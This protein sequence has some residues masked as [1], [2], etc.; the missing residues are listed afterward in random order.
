[1]RTILT[2]LSCTLAASAPALAH[3]PL[4]WNGSQFEVLLDADESRGSIGIFTETVPAPAGPPVHV[5]HDAD[6]ILYLLEGEARVLADG[7]ESNLKTGE[8]AF[9]PKGA[10]HTFRVTSKEGGKLLIIVTPAGFEG[11]FAQVAAKDLKLPEDMERI[12]ELAADYNMRNIA[13]PLSAE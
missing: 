13:P 4:S 6:E 2:A 5:H 12:N 7:H 1:M 3:E 9:V 11:F 10:E 8:L